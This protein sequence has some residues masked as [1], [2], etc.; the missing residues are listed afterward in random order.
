MIIEM[1]LGEIGK[2]RTGEP[3][4]MGPFQIQ[5]M[6]GDF[7]D[8]TGNVMVLHFFEQ[9][10]QIQGFRGG[11]GGRPDLTGKTAINR[12]NDPDFGA[13]GLPDGFQ[14]I[15]GGGFA[16]GAGDTDQRQ[17][18][19]RMIGKG[20]GHMGQGQTGIRSPHLDNPRVGRQVVFDNYGLGPVVDGFG[21]IEVAIG[22][23]T[24][25]SHKDIARLD[26]AGMVC[27]AADGNCFISPYVKDFQSLEKLGQIFPLLLVMS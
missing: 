17:I 2:D 20:G 14:N 21:N 27:Q 6:G 18:M 13:G 24:F 26:P 19:G 23:I 15:G 16:V 1:I 8:G 9:E 12:A 10:L 7:H 3:A 4:G 25:E 5:G 22:L 11:Y